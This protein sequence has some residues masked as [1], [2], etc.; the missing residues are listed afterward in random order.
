MIDDQDERSDKASFAIAVEPVFN[1]EG[2]WEGE[3]NSY[4]EEHLTGDLEEDQIDLIRNVCGMLASCLPLMEEDD[5]FR[6]RIKEYFLDT[7]SHVLE[8]HEE[9]QPVF[10]R[11]KDGNVIHL[12][13]NTKTHG[14]A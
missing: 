9:E 12:S 13:F 4:V 14:S 10:T 11:K 7:F 3:V 5:E 2:K 6:E 8:E 1:D